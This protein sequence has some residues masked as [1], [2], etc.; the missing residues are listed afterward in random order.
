MDLLNKEYEEL[1]QEGYR[2]LAVAYKNTSIIT[3]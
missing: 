3:E 2:A 1:T